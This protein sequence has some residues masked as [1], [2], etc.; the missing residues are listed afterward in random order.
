MRLDVDGCF[1]MFEV[2]DHG[3]GIPL[4]EQQKIFDRFYR[5]PNGSGKAAMA[6]ACSW[7]GTSWKRTAAASKWKAS[8]AGAAASG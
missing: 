1:V 2:E 8:L 3:C 4:S 6:W 5:I 7:C